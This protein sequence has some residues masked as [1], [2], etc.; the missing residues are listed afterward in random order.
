MSPASAN[1]GPVAPGTKV[2][3]LRLPEELAAEIEA[4][5]RVEKVSVSEAIR[6]G[7]YRYIAFRR[8]DKDFQQR[9]RK[10]M[11]EDLAVIERLAE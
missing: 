7:V 8:A 1:G 2:M 10:Q 4:I 11:E 6:A 5:A 9:L 3:S